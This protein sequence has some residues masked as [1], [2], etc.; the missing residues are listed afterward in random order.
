MSGGQTRFQVTIAITSSSTGSFAGGHSHF[1]GSISIASEAYAVEFGPPEFVAIFV[2]PAALENPPTLPEYH[3]GNRLFRH[4]RSRPVGHN[5]FIYSNNTVS[6][7]EPDG[8]TTL[9]RESDRMGDTMPN[10][11]H[12]VKVFWGGHEAELI[13]IQQRSLLV[14]AGYTVGE[15]PM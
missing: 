2:C 5:V 12:V 13:T 1:A 9:W 4:Y 10:A 14:A 8:T 11:P 3:P 6:E 15:V 7:Q